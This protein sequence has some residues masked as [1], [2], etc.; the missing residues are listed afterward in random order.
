MQNLGALFHRLQ[1]KGIVYLSHHLSVFGF[2]NNCCKANGRSHQ[3][4]P[5][6]TVY[7][8]LQQLRVHPVR[9]KHGSV[10]E[11]T[12][13]G[14]RDLMFYCEYTFDLKRVWVKVKRVWMLSTMSLLGKPPI[15]AVQMQN[16]SLQAI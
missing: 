6:S 13:S 12:P 15:S 7:E 3:R 4:Q 8:L 16:Q 10:S 11:G 1:D 2:S 9:G 14:T 5:T